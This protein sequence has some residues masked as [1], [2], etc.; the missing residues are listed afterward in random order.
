MGLIT[1]AAL[2]PANPVPSPAPIPAKK[3]TRIVMRI[4]ILFLSFQDIIHIFLHDVK[5]VEKDL[6]AYIIGAI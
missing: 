4:C 5:H 6:F 1:A 2:M 3:V